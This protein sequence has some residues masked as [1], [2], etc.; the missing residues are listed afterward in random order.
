MCLTVIFPAPLMRTIQELG[1][2]LNRESQAA[3][4]LATPPILPIA[5]TNGELI[6]S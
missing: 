3:G 4:N 5:A 1:S 2:F 6:P